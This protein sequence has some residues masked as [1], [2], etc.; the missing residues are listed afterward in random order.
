MQKGRKKKPSAQVEQLAKIKAIHDRKYPLFEKFHG[1][2][3]VPSY[4]FDVV[5]AAWL[6]SIKEGVST[7]RDKAAEMTSYE[8]KEYS[9]KFKKIS[10]QCNTL[11]ENIERVSFHGGIT[12]A[13]PVGLLDIPVHYSELAN[14]YTLQMQKVAMLTGHAYGAENLKASEAWKKFDKYIQTNEKRIAKIHDGQRITKANTEHAVMSAFTRIVNKNDKKTLSKMS[15]RQFLKLVKDETGKVKT[16]SGEEK[17][18]ST[19]TI[20]NILRGRD[21]KKH[22]FY[23]WDKE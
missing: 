13:G 14:N 18:P 3:L 6:K 1:P 5:C 4:Q 7:L 8:M 23:P 11:L 12:I 15:E 9:S 20:K 2:T 22:P 19:E 16:V 10:D 17:S 21:K